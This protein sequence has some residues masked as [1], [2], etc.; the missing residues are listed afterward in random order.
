VVQPDDDAEWHRGYAILG[1]VISVS[2][3]T[4]HAEIALLPDQKADLH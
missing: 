2:K 1:L 4:P 3:Y